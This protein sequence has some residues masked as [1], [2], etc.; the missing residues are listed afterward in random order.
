[1]ENYT[2]LSG[3]MPGKSSGN[4][5]EIYDTTLIDSDGSISSI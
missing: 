4:T 2:F 5:S 3:G 1:M